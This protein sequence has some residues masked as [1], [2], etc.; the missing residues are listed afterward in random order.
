MDTLRD[1]EDFRV[2]VV[3]TASG[4]RAWIVYDDGVE[5]VEDVE[6]G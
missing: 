2:V 4:W 6:V 5:L 3:A 1:V